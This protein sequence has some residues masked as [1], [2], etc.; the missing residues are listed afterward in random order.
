M[1]FLFRLETAN[2]EPAEPATLNS[3]VPNWNAGDTIPLG[4]R[5][6]VVVGKRDDDVDQPPMLIVEEE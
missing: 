4:R 2:G 6:L 3:A 5:T 1:A